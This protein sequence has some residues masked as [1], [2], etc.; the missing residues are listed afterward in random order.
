MDMHYEGAPAGP[1]QEREGTPVIFSTLEFEDA[2]VTRD[3][4][5]IVVCRPQEGLKAPWARCD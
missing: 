5:K 2:W 4:L 3:G 1:F